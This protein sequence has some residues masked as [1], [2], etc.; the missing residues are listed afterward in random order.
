MTKNL[1]SNMLNAFAWTSIDR[2]GQQIVQFVIGVI[3][4]RILSPDDYGLMGMIVIFIALS[5]VLVDGGFGQ[6]LIKKQNA[7]EKDF[8][9]IFFLNIV[10]SILL[11][12]VLFLISPL[13]SNFFKQP[14]LTDLL[15]VLSLTTLFY[16]IY[17]IQHVQMIKRLQ[18]R[19]LATINIVTVM[20][21]GVIGILMAYKNFG[22]WALVGQQL[23][24]QLIRTI[25]FPIV[26]RWKPI[27]RF[28]VNVIKDFWG[29]SIP[30]LGTTLLNVVFNNIYVV[31]LGK[32]YPKKVVGYF[33]QANKY[34]D[35]VNVAFQ[36]ILLSSTYPLLVQIQDDNERL[37]RIQSRL[38]NT[39]SLIFFPLVAVLIVVAKP[40]IL[41]LITDK[42]IAS[43]VF[44][45]LL[46]IANIFNPIYNLNISLLNSKGLTKQTFNLEL[47]KKGLIVL[48]IVFCFSYGIQVMLGGFILASFFA[49]LLSMFYLRKHIQYK[50][51]LQII[52]IIPAFLIGVLI[53]GLVS[54]FGL[55]VV[56]NLLLLTI[57]LTAALILYLVIVRLVYPDLFKGALNYI[58]MKLSQITEKIK[59]KN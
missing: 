55:M 5:T 17:F 9:T 21:S 14:Q 49:F 38:I 41:V 6:A 13:V 36:Q 54:L 22:V 4:A 57:Q 3:L 32:Y 2:F 53:G 42:W 40:L 39:I 37:R 1:K 25:L 26:V 27:R 16:S 43:V 48:S 8:S 18:F 7:T 50:I 28:S 20:I 29:F 59:M 46:L 51:R 23:S 58:Q 34:S 35:T 19:S 24:N 45:Q 33:F 30:M 44:L 31:L 56:S 47:I 12:I 52:N 10:I 11:Y 15:R